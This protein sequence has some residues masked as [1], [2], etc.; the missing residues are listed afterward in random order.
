MS[1]CVR[2]HCDF[3]RYLS[4]CGKKQRVNCIKNASPEEIRAILEV[5]LNTC[6]GHVPIKK[7]SIQQLAPFKKTFRKVATRSDRGTKAQKKLI[8][9]RGGAFVPILLGTVLPYII[10]QLFQTKNG[11]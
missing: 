7:S 1:Q 11:T 2:K 10:N 6:K 8:L 5:A 9:Q 3:L 4:N